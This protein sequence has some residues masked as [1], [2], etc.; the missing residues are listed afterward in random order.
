M[1]NKEFTKRS[2]TTVAA[3]QR[4]ISGLSG[5]N[6][7]PLTNNRPETII[8][9]KQIAAMANHQPNQPIQKKVYPKRSRRENNTGL[10]DRLKSGIENLSGYAM[11]DVKVHYN[12]NKP[13]QLQA[14]AYAQGTDIHLGPGQEKHL[15]HEAWHVVQQKQGRVQPTMQMKGKVNINDDVGLEKEADVMGGKAL[16]MKEKESLRRL[17]PIDNNFIQLR[18]TKKKRVANLIEEEPI[19]KDTRDLK[20]IIKDSK[21]TLSG[22]SK[23]GK[24]KGKTKRRIKKRRAKKGS[25][26]NWI[27]PEASTTKG[28]ELEFARVSYEQPPKLEGL[29]QLMRGATHAEYYAS[30]QKVGGLPIKIEGDAAGKLELVTPPLVVTPQN[31]VHVFSKWSHM[32]KRAANKKDLGEA[33]TQIEQ[34]TGIRLYP[35]IKGIRSWFLDFRHGTGSMG[36]FKLG[37]E[38]GSK[39]AMKKKVN[40]KNLREILIKPL[41][42]GKGKNKLNIHVNEAIRSNNI[43]EVDFYKQF[44]ARSRRKSASHKAYENARKDIGVTLMNNLELTKGIET[45][46]GRQVG[47]YIVDSAI[48]GSYKKLK[49]NTKNINFISGKQK[50]IDRFSEA[51]NVGNLDSSIKDRSKIF[52]KVAWEDVI[53][54]EIP[55]DVR[56]EVIQEIL[57]RAQ[58]EKKNLIESAR[59]AAE[60]FWQKPTR[61]AKTRLTSDQREQF[62]SDAGTYANEAIEKMIVQLHKLSGL[63]DGQILKNSGDF[64][65]NA[66]AGLLAVRPD[67]LIRPVKSGDDHLYVIEHRG[68]RIRYPRQ[69]QVTE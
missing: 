69:D 36:S 10:P 30:K 49:N 16:Q 42:G 44:G 40:A 64:G 55:I 24:K 26:P 65:E 29:G 51:Q 43:Q 5:G 31:R 35:D 20:K 67:T 15:P 12:S 57:K 7:I 68:R 41:S 33:K 63:K 50:G 25:V 52:L 14:H 62:I 34:E 4:K 21:D 47:A 38:S 45:L 27:L 60:K 37:A 11:D 46:I 9:R 17:Q 8:Q 22:K 39:K 28:Y 66:S 23:K 56:A 3:V 18:R 13:A 48:L 19:E 58:D 2:A 61:K 32:T 54:K 6:A 59:I 1:E 53:M